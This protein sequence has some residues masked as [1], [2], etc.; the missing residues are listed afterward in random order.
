GRLRTLV[1]RIHDAHDLGGGGVLQRHDLHVLVTDLVDAPDDADHA[2]HVVGAVRDDQDVARRVGGEVSILR[3]HR[4]ENGNE[5]R[6]VD[7]LDVD[8]LRDD[9]IGGRAHGVRKVDG[10]AL[11]RVGVGQDLDDAAVGDG[12]E[13][14][15]RQNR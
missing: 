10:R 15:D 1:Q 5:L 13:V 2:V 9:L 7:V 3:N 6:R 11:S 12:D 4:A 8:D 14:I